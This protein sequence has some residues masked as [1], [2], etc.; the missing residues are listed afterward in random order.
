MLSKQYFTRTKLTTYRAT[1]RCLYTAHDRI[2]LKYWMCVL[3]ARH[4]L[5]ELKLSI[6]PTSHQRN[7]GYTSVL[8]MASFRYRKYLM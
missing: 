4:K 6:Y 5:G 2:H 3:H 8:T 1:N 7:V